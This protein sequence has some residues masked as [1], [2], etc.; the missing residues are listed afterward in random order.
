[1][2]FDQGAKV[3]GVEPSMELI[4]EAQLILIQKL[5]I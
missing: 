4:Q 5:N 2:L 3:V 1:M